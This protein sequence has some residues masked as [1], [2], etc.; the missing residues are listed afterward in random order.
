MNNINFFL[1]PKD[2]LHQVSSGLDEVKSFYSSFS[3]SR[4]RRP[5]PGIP[6]VQESLPGIGLKKRVVGKVLVKAESYL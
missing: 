1:K 6:K 3:D 5:T 4:T 2:E